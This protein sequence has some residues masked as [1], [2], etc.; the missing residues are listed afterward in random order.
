MP[1]ALLDMPTSGAASS[2]LPLP[3]PSLPS[4][5]SQGE[6]EVFDGSYQGP[7]QD[8][9]DELSSKIK[10]AEVGNQVKCPY[11]RLKKFVLLKHLV[12]AGVPLAKAK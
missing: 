12:K 4:M 8:I 6:M 9:M 3:G 2:V 5:S 11:N 1:R 7:S 10:K